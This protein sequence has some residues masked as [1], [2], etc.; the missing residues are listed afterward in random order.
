MDRLR[1][2]GLS[3]NKRTSL[4]PFP[5]LSPQLD[6]PFIPS[7]HGMTAV[8]PQQAWCCRGTA[9]IGLGDPQG[10][11]EDADA[12][13]RLDKDSWE[14][15]KIQ[16]QPSFRMGSHW[17]HRYPL[18]AH[19]PVLAGC[20]RTPHPFLHAEFHCVDVVNLHC[21]F[22]RRRGLHILP[23]TIIPRPV[24]FCQQSKSIP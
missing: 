10:A 21:N 4:W 20:W 14:I 22:V 13:L 23:V 9:R 7:V 18:A 16:S 6:F 15:A 24:I 5:P 2:Q 1:M 11:A 3:S 12:A 19:S 17:A 8:C